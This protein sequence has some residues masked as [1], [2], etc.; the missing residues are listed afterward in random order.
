[1]VYVEETSAYDVKMT[2]E[3]PISTSSVSEVAEVSEDP[4]PKD[5]PLD[6]EFQ[7]SVPVD[8]ISETEFEENEPEVKPLDKTN[9]LAKAMKLRKIISKKNESEE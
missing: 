5:K 3:T 9:P 6:Q 2:I 4:T 7:R 1:M 8:I